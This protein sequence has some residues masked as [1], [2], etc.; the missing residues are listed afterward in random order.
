MNISTRECISLA[1]SIDALT[2]SKICLSGRAVFD[3]AFNRFLV[4][5]VLSGYEAMR[6]PPK[7][8]LEYERKYA[9]LREQLIDKDGKYFD[10]PVAVE[11]FNAL[12]TEFE[13]DIAAFDA[14]ISESNVLLYLNHEL[15][16]RVIP[17]SGMS[18]SDS[19]PV[20]VLAGLMPVIDKGK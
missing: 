5:P 6:K 8:M 7:R 18:F 16:L 12:F 14:V 20:A 3:M 2:E 15:D 1:N 19:T 10:R 13:A 11:K 4:T 9:L 17:E